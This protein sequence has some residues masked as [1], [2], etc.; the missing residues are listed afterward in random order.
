MKNKDDYKDFI[1]FSLEKF[2]FK[3]YDFGKK[4]LHILEKTNNENLLINNL[5]NFRKSPLI[6]GDHYPAS[7]HANFFEI[8]Y[9]KSIIKNPLK[10]IYEYIYEKLPFSLFHRSMVK[11]QIELLINEGADEIISA[12]PVSDTPG[13]P[14]YF[15]YKNFY[16]NER[17]LKHYYYLNLISKKLKSEINNNNIKTVLDIGGGYGF[18]NGL[19]KTIFPKTT[20]ILI[21]F[22]HQLIFAYYFFKEKF[23]NAKIL[24]LRNFDN[25]DFSYN[26]LCEYDFVLIPTNKINVLKKNTI[27]IACNFFSFGEMSRNTF[28]N[29]LE[30]DFYKTASYH[31]LC[32]RYESSPYFE[33][34][35][36]NDITILDYKIYKENIIYFG[37]FPLHRFYIKKKF[38]LFAE[39]GIFSSNYYIYLG[40]NNRK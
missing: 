12:F 40:K 25:C 9:I 30:S 1:K 36:D 14:N 6:I 16:I 17:S 31:F 21:D 13:N 18:Y 39:K 2:S 24:D 20:Q 11:E 38:L 10:F 33:K 5:E 35:Y 15:K 32:N 29:Y 22:P 7:R 34:T 3:N 4:W 23:P 19:F 28:N 26:Q 8:F 27:D 37:T